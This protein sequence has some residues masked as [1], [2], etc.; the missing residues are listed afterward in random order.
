[1]DVG[2]YPTRYDSMMWMVEAVERAIHVTV[3]MTYVPV[4]IAF[5]AERVISVYSHLSMVMFDLPLAYMVDNHSDSLRT[6]M[7]GYM[8]L[9]GDHTSTVCH[10]ILFQ[11]IVLYT[12]FSIPPISHS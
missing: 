5:D 7:M 10:A 11:L 1:M 9:M 3:T 12:D 8:T 2:T 6:M 4:K